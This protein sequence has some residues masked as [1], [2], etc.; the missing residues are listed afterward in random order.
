MNVI[1]EQYGYENFPNPAILEYVR[2]R[3][4]LSD[5]EWLE[6]LNPARKT[7]IRLTEI[8]KYIRYQETL[9]QLL[10]DQKLPQMH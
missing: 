8:C 6:S 10:I 9:K 2:N 5:E 4:L 3:T 7:K 1:F